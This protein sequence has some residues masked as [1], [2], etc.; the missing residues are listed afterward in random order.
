MKSIPFIKPHLPSISKLSADI[1]KMYTNLVFSNGG[2]FEM[3]FES[4]TAEYLGNDVDVVA[5]SNATVGLLIS[6][7]A[8]GLTKG[9]ILLPSFTFAAT[10]EA[11]LY[12]GLTPVFVDVDEKDWSMVINDE[13]ENFLKQENVVAILFCNPFGIEGSI[14]AWEK[15]AK[16]YEVPL[17]CD[18]AAGFGSDYSDSTKMGTKGDIE[19]FSLHA[20]KTFAVG[21]G[22]LVVTKDAKIAEDVRRL[23]NFGFNKDRI[24]VEPGINGKMGEIY[25]IIGLHVLGTID[26]MVSKKHHI[27]K[28]YKKYL[29]NHVFIHPKSI[30]SALQFLP[31]CF[32]TEKDRR[33]AEDALQKNIIGCKRYYYPALHNHIA[34][35]D[36]MRIGQLTGTTQL[37]NCILALPTYFDLTDIQIK[38]ICKIINKSLI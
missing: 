30:N 32:P 28:I 16:Q 35:K 7:K 8:L 36:I 2:E 23:R 10:V 13:V 34:F 29:N 19:V 5:V 3:Q 11:V 25:S 12:S 31:I 14:I 38:F 20:T 27:L 18:S 33:I 26:E 17:I 21:E 1:E 24:V 4:K 6:L 9:Y 22:G 37:E 15:L